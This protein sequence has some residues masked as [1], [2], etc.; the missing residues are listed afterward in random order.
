MQWI[1]YD[2]RVMFSAVAVF[3]LI[4]SGKPKQL[5]R[6]DSERENE[7]EGDK[8]PILAVKSNWQEKSH[9]L[10]GGLPHPAAA[11][12]ALPA[13]GGDADGQITDGRP[14][15]GLANERGE[16]QQRRR[17]NSKTNAE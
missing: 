1:I 9:S 8:R 6:N 13:F 7:K 12:A 2:E 14:S 16:K 15:S 3:L 11:A 4:P 10:P 5:V 17:K